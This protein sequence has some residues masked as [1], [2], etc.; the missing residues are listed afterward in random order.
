M[1]YVVNFTDNSLVT[2]DYLNDTAAELGG[3]VLAF[4]DDMT[5][6]VDD[7][8]GISA[9]LITKGVTRGC[10]LSVAGNQVTIAE[11]V[12]YMSDGRRVVIDTDGVTLDYTAGSINY[13]WFDYDAVTGFVAPRCTVEEPAADDY[14]ILGRITAEGTIEGKPDRAVMKN[15]FLGLHGFETFTK[16]FGWNGILEETLLWELELA[17]LGYQ[18]V[19][20]YSEGTP[21]G[22]YIHNA[23]CGTVNLA[24]KTAFS[25]LCTIAY[26]YDGQIGMKHTSDNCEILAAYSVYSSVANRYHRVYLRFEL[27][28]DNVLRVYQ[29][30]ANTGGAGY[31][32]SPAVQLKIIVC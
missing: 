30:A 2:A 7:L 29:R 24:D 20:I 23:C 28:T 25:S 18:Q 14:V 32:N 9:E 4:G 22:T 17:D 13:V 26:G 10:G 5:Y 12:L 21:N 27:G 8:N 11:G 15:P 19:I 16:T 3:G 6:G 1:G 31:N